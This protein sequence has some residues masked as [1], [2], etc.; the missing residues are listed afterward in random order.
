MSQFISLRKKEDVTINY[1]KLAMEQLQ[2]ENYDNSLNYLKQALMV[3]KG[4]NDEYKKNKLMAVTY[5]NLGIFFK[6]MI[7]F[8]EALKYLYKTTE[9][10][11]RLPNEISTIA[12]AHLN[13]CSILSEQGDHS[14]A[15]RHGLR[16]VF[17]L[18][19]GCKAQPKLAS[20]LVI[21]YYNVANEYSYLG[22]Q[23]NAEDCYRIG[24]KISAEELGLQHRLTIKLKAAL[25]NYSRKM[26]PNYERF[27]QVNNKI[28]MSPK[29]VVPVISAKSRSTSQD[30]SKLL[31]SSGLPNGKHKN[32]DYELN[33]GTTGMFGGTRKNLEIKRPALDKDFFDESI[34][35]K[36]EK[37]FGS[38]KSAGKK[39]DI[40]RHKETER[41]A[42]TI[43]QSCWRGYKARKKYKELQFNLELKQAESKARRAVEEYEKLKL[44]ASKIT[45]KYK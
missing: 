17:I 2:I 19:S 12:G 8:P 41:I 45:K 37:S 20:T 16:S 7:N 44:Q 40:F 38:T 9:L 30:S 6:R 36:T 5:N 28:S 14:R 18:K 21:A 32:L 29:T 25:G 10:E 24:L 39:I 11:N 22:Q 35:V 15:I 42:A 1:N 26:S 23:G 34:S 13:I 4:I 27:R 3:I 31:N 33:I 43:I